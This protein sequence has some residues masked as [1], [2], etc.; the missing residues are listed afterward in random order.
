[1]VGDVVMSAVLDARE[2]AVGS[3]VEIV[4]E[5]QPGVPRLYVDG[6]RLMQALTAV[7]QSAV[8]FTREGH[9]RTCA[10]RSLRAPTEL[11][12]DVESSGRMAPRTE[13]E[14]LFDAFKDAESRAPSRKPRARPVARA[15]DPPS[16]RRVRG[17]LGD[18]ARRDGLPHDHPDPGGAGARGPAPGT[19]QHR[20]SKLAAA[21][22]HS[23]AR[24]ACLEDEAESGRRES[25]RRAY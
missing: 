8:R 16:A 9:G 18:E 4:A 7:I 17:R 13:R 25:R 12:V 19:G 15:I 24:A 11:R 22:R 2:L 23:A 1:M 5:I 20:L 21:I 3:G 6:R 14:K 10:R